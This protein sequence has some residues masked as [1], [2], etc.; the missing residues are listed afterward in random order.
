MDRITN[1]GDTI[2]RYLFDYSDDEFIELENSYGIY[3]KFRSGLW[4]VVAL[5]VFFLWLLWIV[6]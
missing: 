3:A 4:K 6:T 5:G 2:K 1:K